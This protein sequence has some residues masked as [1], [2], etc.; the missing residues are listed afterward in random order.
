MQ[1]IA[2]QSQSI[3]TEFGVMPSAVAPE[4]NASPGKAKLATKQD[5][6][7][8]AFLS[9]AARRNRTEGLGGSGPEAAASRCTKSTGHS[10]DWCAKDARDR[11]REN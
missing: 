10:W 2:E 5:C 6:V 9:S 8:W 1:I 11:A 4:L 3:A 7:Y